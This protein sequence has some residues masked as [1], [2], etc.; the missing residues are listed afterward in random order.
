MNLNKYEQDNATVLELTGKLMGGPDARVVTETL[1]QLAEEGVRNV[2]LDLENVT[3]INSSGLSMLIAGLKTLKSHDARLLLANV[4]EKV[5]QLLQMTRLNNVFQSF[6]S[7]ETAI[8]S[9]D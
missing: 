8:E 2:V 6:D 3:M 9:L 7:V 5:A 4:P 1:E